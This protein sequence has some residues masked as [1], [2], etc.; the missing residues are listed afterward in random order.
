MSEAK[1]RNVDTFEYK[2]KVGLAALR[3]GKTINQVGQ[4]FYVYPVQVGQW[5]KAIQEQAKTLY[6][7]NRSPK[8]VDAQ[9]VLAPIEGVR[10][11]V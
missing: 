6:Q 11:F 4:E 8:P 1:K 9:S 7:G 3:S 5:K 2:A 10:S